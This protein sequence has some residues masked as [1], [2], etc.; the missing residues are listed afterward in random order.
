MAAPK[1]CLV[2]CDGVLKHVNTDG[3][4][5]ASI[6]LNRLNSATISAYYPDYVD[7]YNNYLNEVF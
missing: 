3:V 1:T 2:F 6:D 4:T 7:I 5:V